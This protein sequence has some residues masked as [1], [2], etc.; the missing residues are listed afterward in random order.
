MKIE[1]RGGKNKKVNFNPFI[2]INRESEYFLGL[3]MADGW[4]T[5]KKYSIG[6]KLKDFSIIEKYR[7]FINKDLKIYNYNNSMY[8][9]IFG[10]KE[11]HSWLISIGITP[12]KSLTLNINIP[13]TWDIFR[14]IFDGDGYAP[15]KG[16]N[17]KITSGSIK[18]LEQIQE[19]L[20]FYNIYSRIDIQQK[21]INTTYCLK[22]FKASYKELYKNMY[23]NT[24]L[25]LERKHD[26]MRLIA[27][28]E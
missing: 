16:Q 27:E 26:K 3:L 28:M 19:F 6:L 17:A 10:N 23:N 25:F 15:I 2:P 20:K 13:I 18:F 21:L 8:S 5:S 11:V 9:V 12:R 22:L 1:N 4:V 7:D 24:N 14:G